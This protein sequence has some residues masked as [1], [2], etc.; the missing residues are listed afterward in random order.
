MA[1]SPHHTSAE[2][3][4]VNVMAPIMA[5][6]LAII[7]GLVWDASG[8]MNAQQRAHTVAAQA[9]RAAG[10][11]LENPTAVR[12][13][14][15]IADPYAA[16]RAANTFISSAGMTGGAQVIGGDTIVVDTSSTYNTRFL[17]IIGISHLPVS[18]HAE[19]RIAR[20]FGGVEQ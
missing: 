16:A 11:Q 7:L 8:Q 12:G 2:T 18:G 17:T 1:A 19:A 20:T 13:N 5:I 6:A 4:S 3:G 10:Q 15:A 9:A 14:A